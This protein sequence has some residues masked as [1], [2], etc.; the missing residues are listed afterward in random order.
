MAASRSNSAAAADGTSS[1]CCA[2]AGRCSRSTPRRRRSNDSP[3]GRTCPGAG[4][5]KHR[6]RPFRRRRMAGCRPRQ[7][8]LRAA[9]LP[10]G[11][12]SRAVVADH[13]LARFARRPVRRSAIRGPRRVVR[14]S[15][16]HVSHGGRGR[17]AAAR[18]RRR[19]FQGRGRRQHHAARP[20]QALAHLPY[21]R[22][23]EGV[24]AKNP[25][26]RGSHPVSPS[27]RP[28]PRRGEGG[29]RRRPS[30]YLLP[31][32][33][34]EGPGEGGPIGRNASAVIC[35]TSGSGA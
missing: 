35:R 20:G 4:A 17:R 12:V 6:R 15:L 32:R 33:S 8:Q 29:L 23:E 21:R 28:S 27:P 11:G 9:A 13:R 26:G 22:A 18:P 30:P 5:L 31:S 34:R 14:R 19:V 2:G 24:K 7:F 3:C 1:N 16:D 25:T 10:A